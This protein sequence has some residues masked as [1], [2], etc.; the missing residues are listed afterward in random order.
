MNSLYIKLRYK[1]L[2]MSYIK[3][4]II[5]LKLC[6]HHATLCN[7]ATQLR[8]VITI[9]RAIPLVDL[10]DTFQLIIA[11]CPVTVLLVPVKRRTKNAQRHRQ[12]LCHGMANP[13]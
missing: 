13:K 5:I 7:Y 1:Y 11:A 10:K 12:L 9:T 8:N 3:L 6:Y 4:N 2:Y